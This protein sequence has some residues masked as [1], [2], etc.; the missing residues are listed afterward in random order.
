MSIT[1]RSMHPDEA[2][3][4]KMLAARTFGLV[5]KLFIATPKTAVVA[6]LEDKIAGGM[7][8]TIKK[9]G[10]KK[11]GYVELFFIDKTIR[12]KGIGKQ[13]CEKTIKLLWESG[14]DLIG[15]YVRDDNA[16]SW[17]LFR[18]NG[19]VRISFLKL[20]RFAGIAE[21]VKQYTIPTFGLAL[22]HDKYFVLSEACRDSLTEKRSGVSQIILFA[23]IP[24]LLL[25][26]S[27]ISSNNIFDIAYL[28]AAV[29][30]VFLGSVLAGFFSTLFSGQKWRFRLTNG[31]ISICILISYAFNGLLPMVGNW[32]PDTYENTSRHRKELAINSIIVWLYLLI[33]SV[34]P[35]FINAPISIFR[36]ASGFASALIIFRCI[37]IIPFESYG[38]GRV[39]SWNKIVFFLLAAISIYVALIM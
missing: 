29:M 15:T 3:E 22:G 35:A 18:E 16:A 24:V 34:A 5:E 9:C 39:F 38:G 21:A 7:I 37:P 26:R 12:G 32:Y 25:G 10:N 1:I 31:G 30:L 4:T 19:F 33:I 2:R 23:L 27:F 6:V 20:A 28:I 8:Y 17:K 14:C 11:I 13:L 36:Y